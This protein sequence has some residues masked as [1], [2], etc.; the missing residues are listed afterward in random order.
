[1]SPVCS[2]I[3]FPCSLER[4][5]FSVEGLEN[6][7]LENSS[8]GFFPALQ[9][10]MEK[11]LLGDPE[12]MHRV[13]RSSLVRDVL[14]TSSP[15]LTRQLILSNPQMQ[16]LLQ[17]NPEVED[18]LSNADVIDQVW[19]W[20]NRSFQ[21]SKCAIKTLLLCLL[22][23]QVLEIIRKPD[24]IDEMMQSGDED[25]DGLFQYE[26][27]TAATDAKTQQPGLKPSQVKLE[28]QFEYLFI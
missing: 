13:L 6:L 22:P 12:M 10:E 7:D 15:R 14:S 1:M 24:L 11:Q 19:E 17:T 9:S 18:M 2:L 21:R 23:L 3:H 8:P 4:T 20:H 27:S 16:Q 26:N 5:L 25:L 28:S